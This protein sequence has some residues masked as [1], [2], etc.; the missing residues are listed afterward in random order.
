VAR[1]ACSSAIIAIES[2]MG[3]EYLEVCIKKFSC[4][5]ELTNFFRGVLSAL[6]NNSH[7]LNLN[8]IYKALPR[9]S[10]LVPMVLE[11]SRHHGSPE[12]AIVVA[13]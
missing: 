11:M 9:C 5:R 4:R 7:Q 1:I 8:P 2:R 3:N 12:R 6:R 13:S 10:P